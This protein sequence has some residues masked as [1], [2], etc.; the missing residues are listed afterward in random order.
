MGDGLKEDLA[1]P[2]RV[3]G[4]GRVV[5]G[6]SHHYL[7]GLQVSACKGAQERIITEVHPAC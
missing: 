3:L 4:E 6:R 5:G 1:E 2:D 7:L